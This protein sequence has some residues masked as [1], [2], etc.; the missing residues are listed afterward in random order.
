[1]AENAEPPLELN[2]QMYQKL[3][4]KPKSEYLKT[5]KIQVGT[6]NHV[7]DEV[8]S[9]L[10]YTLNP[11]ATNKTIFLSLNALYSLVASAQK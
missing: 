6:V 2:H 4:E 11:F 10:Y 1:M 3:K 7:S 5:T 8:T 9:L